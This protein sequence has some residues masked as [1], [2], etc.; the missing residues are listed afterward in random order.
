MSGNY[1]NIAKNFDNMCCFLFSIPFD[2]G[3][4]ITQVAEF[5]NN[6]ETPGRPVQNDGC[7][8]C[9]VMI[10]IIALL[11]FYLLVFCHPRF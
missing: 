7:S 6:D 9:F 11:V 8:G 10:I 5:A 4:E 2:D 3:S 1:R